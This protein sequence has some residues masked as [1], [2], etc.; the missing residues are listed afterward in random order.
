MYLCRVIFRCQ[1]LLFRRSYMFSLWLEVVWGE[2]NS[3]KNV[4]ESTVFS[5]PHMAANNNLKAE[6]ETDKAEIDLN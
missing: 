6:G 3:M 2:E 5:F 4:L 1:I